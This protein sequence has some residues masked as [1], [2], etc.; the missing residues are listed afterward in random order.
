MTD[1]PVIET[2]DSTTIYGRALELFEDS[3]FEEQQTFVR[4]ILETV[5][6]ESIETEQF[7]FRVQEGL[8]YDPDFEQLLSEWSDVLTGWEIT[9]MPQSMSQKIVIYIEAKTLD[10]GLVNADASHFPPSLCSEH[11]RTVN[12]YLESEISVTP[13]FVDDETRVTIVVE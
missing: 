12:C 5:V 2:V 8:T 3:T 10:T 11:R 1:E 7:D 6:T 9:P 13:M 4:G